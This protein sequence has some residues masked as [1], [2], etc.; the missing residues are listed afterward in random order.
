M[1]SIPA[2]GGAAV[3]QLIEGQAALASIGL[4]AL[5]TGFLVAMVSGVL[6]I[7]LFVRLLETR[8]FRWFAYYCWLVGGSYLLA[9]L[10]MAELR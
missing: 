4:P 6:A 2:I 8:H 3:L 10:A 1:L 9:A 5:L 7:R